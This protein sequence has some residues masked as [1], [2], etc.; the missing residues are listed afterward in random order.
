MTFF[1]ISK[2]G[3]PSKA[4]RI[5]HT[6][7]RPASWESPAAEGH[8][9]SRLVIFGNVQ[10]QNPSVTCSCSFSSSSS[11][12]AAPQRHLRYQ[13]CAFPRLSGLVREKLKIGQKN[14]QKPA[15]TSRNQQKPAKTSKNQQNPAQWP[16]RQSLSVPNLWVNRVLCVSLC[17]SDFGPHSFLRYLRWL[18]LNSCAFVSIRGCSLSDFT[19]VRQQTIFFA[20]YILDAA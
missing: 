14:Q 6:A 10:P 8:L 12:S 18:L 1:E 7:G 20:P 3:L 17:P 16:M 2:T 9:W 13:L 4:W 5:V 11:I 15:E 19:S